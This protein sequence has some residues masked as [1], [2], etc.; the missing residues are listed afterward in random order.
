MPNDLTPPDPARFDLQSFADLLPDRAPIIGEDRGSFEGFRT[1][2]MQSLLPITPYEGVIAE[3]L[4]AIEWELLQ[5]RRMRDAGLRTIIKKRVIEAVVARER[6]AYEADLDEAREK[7]EA[8]GGTDD[9][10]EWPFEFDEEAAKED[11]Q[12]LAR[13]A[14][15]LDPDIFQAACSDIEDMGLDVVEI[16]GEAYRTREAEVRQ[17]ENKLPDLERRRREVMRDYDALQRARPIEAEVI[18]G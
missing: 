2:M 1:G 17:H 13:N 5:H 8:A 18:E 4:I 14:V 12:A 9:D 10:W 16:M 15:S 3:N 7:H 11:G 6:A